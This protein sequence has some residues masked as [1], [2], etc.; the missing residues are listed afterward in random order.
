MHH[1]ELGDLRNG[2]RYFRMT[3]KLVQGSRRGVFSNV[4]NSYNRV[5]DPMVI[6]YI[7][8]ATNYS[9]FNERWSMQR[10]VEEA[11]SGRQLR[12]SSF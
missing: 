10:C 9:L 7:E 4:L 12:V 8:A 6:S 11:L 3:E 2:M 5:I 1:S